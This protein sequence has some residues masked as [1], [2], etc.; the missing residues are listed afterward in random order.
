MAGARAPDTNP[1]KPILQRSRPGMPLRA[2]SGP[3]RASA[4]RSTED[5]ASLRDA[6]GRAP[7]ESA[8]QFRLPR[9][10]RHQR[11]RTSGPAGGVGRVA[12]DDCTA[13]DCALGCG[14]L[15]CG[16]EAACWDGD[17]G[18][19]ILCLMSSW[20]PCTVAMFSAI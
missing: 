10:L 6:E 13:D 5:R 20:T 8:Y 17:G 4:G 16:I 11:V 7:K 18:V 9:N 1:A 14:G 15:G 2:M 3:W 12:G 19:Y